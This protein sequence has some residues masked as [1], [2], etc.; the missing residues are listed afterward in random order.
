MKL[1]EETLKE[2]LKET[3]DK[4]LHSELWRISFRKS[5]KFVEDILE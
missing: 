5:W 4:F 3:Q 2:L 1:L